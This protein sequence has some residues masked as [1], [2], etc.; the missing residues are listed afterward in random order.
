VAAEVD[1][2]MDAGS[3]AI[4][5]RGLAKSFSGR[6]VLRGIDIKVGKGESVV[7]FGPN[8]AGKTTLIKILATIMNPTS[9]S[10]MV[11]GLDPGENPEA[12]RRRIGV[13]THQTFLYGT[14]TAFE[15]L[16]FYG[17][18]YDVARP[19]ERIEEVAALVGMTSRLHD[20][21]GAFS[22]G[23]QQRL[24]IARALLHRPSVMLL[25]EPETGLDQ[26]A[27]L[28]LR[29]ALRAEAGTRP[30]IVLT[31][32]N[33]ERGLEL[34]DRLLILARGSIAYERPTR[35]LDLA[36][37]REAYCECTGVRP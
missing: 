15:N 5:T 28:V 32:H 2:K 3:W 18:L 33:L 26:E 25:D 9:G 4:E 1:T 35:A 34:S 12:I 17:R 19:R 24:S 27:I 11:D 7:I 29:D 30:S 21:T 6:R 10:F 20:R 31:T 22:R 36:G 23:M 16:E 13:I 37:L 14:L 8:G